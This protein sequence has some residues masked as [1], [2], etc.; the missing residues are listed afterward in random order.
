MLIDDIKKIK[1]EKSD[2]RKFGLTV[3]IVLGLLGG[4]LWWRGKD[5]YSYFLVIAAVLVFAG[6]I[7]PS[8][9]KPIQKAWMTIA[10]VIGWFMT[11]VILTVLFYVVVSF[12][13]FAAKLFGKDFLDKKFDK[14]TNKNIN[15]YWIPKEKIKADKSSYENQF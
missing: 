14:N 9:L 13:G 4:L 2:L 8:V 15:S 3:G 1:S 6:L 11:R 12:T 5:F 10:V 7:I